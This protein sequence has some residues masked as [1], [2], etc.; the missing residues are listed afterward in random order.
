MMQSTSINTQVELLAAVALWIAQYQP[1]RPYRPLDLTAALRVPM[2]QLA[3][4]LELYG[5]RRTSISSQQGT[6][7]VRRVW[8]APRGIALPRPSRG[9][10]S[11]LDMITSRTQNVRNPEPLTQEEAHK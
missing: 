10:P 6:R 4:V 2:N 7:C 5:W 3:P 11:L 8:W 1:R 9:R